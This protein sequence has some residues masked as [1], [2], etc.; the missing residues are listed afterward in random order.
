[1]APKRAALTLDGCIRR[2]SGREQLGEND[3]WY[4]RGC[5]EH[6]RA[7]KKMDVWRLPPVLIV[8]LKRFQYER[9]IYSSVLR[10][11][12]CPHCIRGRG[13]LLLL[14]LRP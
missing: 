12:A 6:V 9:G 13:C 3:K 4:C 1:V 7:F 10:C 5:K 14:A 2:F 11:V 8:H